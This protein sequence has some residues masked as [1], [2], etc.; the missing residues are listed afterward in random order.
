MSKSDKKYALITW[1][2]IVVILIVGVSIASK[3]I[4][5]SK[6]QSCPESIEGNQDSILK[7]KYLHLESCFFCQMQKPILNELLAEHGDLFHIETYNVKHCGKE[8]VQY[9]LPGTPFFIFE[10]KDSDE[11]KTH[12]GLIE[13][14][15]LK[16]IICDVSGGCDV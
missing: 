1:A 7:I 5:N 12:A 8:F 4:L 6:P 11:T 15:A 16:G 2:A 13:K 10:F 9:G 3:N 14:E